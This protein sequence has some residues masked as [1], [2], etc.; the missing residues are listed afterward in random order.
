[1]IP[2]RRAIAAIAFALCAC[3]SNG[4]SE[5]ASPAA[6]LG[7]SAVH[8]VSGLPVIDLAVKGK[9][10]PHAFR[11]ELARTA[12]EQAKGL[13]FRTEM[14]P[15][16]GMLFPMEPPRQASFWMRNTVIPLDLVFVGEDH[17]VLN[18]AANAVPYDESQL[19]S[20][21]KVIAVLELN[22]GRAAEL[23]IAPGDEVTWTLPAAGSS[24]LG[25]A[26]EQG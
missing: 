26:A 3:S 5:A 1:M 21:G 10:G 24:P 23:G 15:D 8:P 14:G 9:G 18:I 4:P 6:S 16:E 13:M 11:V 22:G 20:D 19:K 17:H 7:Q 2:I 25:T 12:Q